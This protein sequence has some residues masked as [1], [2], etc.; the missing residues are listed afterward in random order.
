MRTGGG[1]GMIRTLFSAFQRWRDFPVIPVS[2]EVDT[3]PLHHVRH[4]ARRP[5]EP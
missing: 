5:I 4:N 1:G 2:V 3:I